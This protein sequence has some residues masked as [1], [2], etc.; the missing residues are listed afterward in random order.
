V[1]PPSIYL[2]HAATTPMRPEVLEAMLPWLTEHHGNPTSLHRPGRD[3]RRAIDQARDQVAALL[4]ADPRE[5]IF[6]SGGTEANNLTLRG[7][8]KPGGH[9]LTSAIEHHS[10]LHTAQA[11]EK[12]GGIEL[13]IAPVSTDGCVTDF[14]THLIDDTTLVSVMHGN[15]ETGVLQPIEPIAAACRTRNIP[16][17][18]D[19][20]QST[21]KLPLDVTQIPV[22]LL[23]LSAHKLNGPKGIGALYV[24]HRINL[25][26]QAIGGTQERARRAGTENVPAIVGLGVACELARQEMETAR[27]AQLRD[28]L[29]Q[30]ILKQIPGTWLNGGLGHRLPHITNIGFPDTEGEQIMMALDAAGIAVSTGSACTSGSV[31]PSHVLLAMGQDHAQAHGGVR[32]SL[33]REN[34]PADIARVVEAL[35][36]IT[37]QN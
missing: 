24:R 31:D 9:L 4:N 15:N 14:E 7:L 25:T 21:G 33:G 10:I 28:Q 23:S 36:K 35:L 2:D 5:I 32:F 6:T 29:E 17:H 18:T 27:L 3:A 26:P 30:A 13:T 37:G 34:T 1:S 16:F 20:I 19:A 22:D 8:L 12:H 11:L